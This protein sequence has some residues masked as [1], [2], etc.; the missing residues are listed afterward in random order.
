MNI[1]TMIYGELV[2][3]DEL[4]SLGEP[5]TVKIKKITTGLSKY[6]GLDKRKPAEE[7]VFIWFDWFRGKKERAIESCKKTNRCMRAMFGK[8]T[9]GWIGKSITIVAV[10]EEA[11]GR[12]QPCVRVIGS[13]DITEPIQLGARVG[14]EL[15]R[16]TMQ[17]TGKGEVKC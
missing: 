15:R 3:G 11:F 12:M 16:L 17:P 9:D 4:E 8:E 6:A 13:P 1:D 7:K 5:V 10:Q 2:T 14:L